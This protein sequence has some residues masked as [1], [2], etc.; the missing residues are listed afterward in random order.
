MN[1]ISDFW[2][3]IFDE[4]QIR[5]SKSYDRVVDDP[6]VMPGTKWFPGAKLNFAE[7][8]LRFRDDREALVAWREDKTVK[9]IT[10]RELYDEVSRLVKALKKLGI[11][12]GDRVAGYLPNGIHAVVAMLATTSLGAIWSSG[13]PDFGVQGATDRFGQIEP[14]VLFCTDSYLYN[15]K[16]FGRLDHA[17][18]IAKNIGSIKHIVVVPFVDE[19][20]D[21]GQL[22]EAVHYNDLIADEVA[23]DIEFV[24]TPADHPVY[25]LYSSGTTGV[26]KCIVHGAIGV[27]LQHYKEL[28]LH[29]GVTRDSSIFYFTTCGWMMWN[30][31]VS[32]LMLGARTV[33]FDGSPFYPGPEILWEMARKRKAHRLRHERQVPVRTGRFRPETP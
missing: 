23:G 21:L 33:L 17:A 26:P 16:T 2:G 8:L 30:W 31:L 7:N 24:Q 6:N 4:A 3:A 32:S 1:N 12:Q 27:L 15:G 5:T 13:S 14:K 11:T 18:E 9:R 19:R 29:T 28:A 22:P 20:P 25:I 10:Y